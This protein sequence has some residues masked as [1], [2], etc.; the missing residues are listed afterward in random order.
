MVSQ[1]TGSHHQSQVAPRE[2]FDNGLEARLARL[3]SAV[4]AL[5]EAV[6]RLL[7]PSDPSPRRAGG[8]TWSEPPT[9]SQ[10]ATDDIPDLELE[11]LVYLRQLSDEDVSQRLK[12]LEERYRISSEAF[13]QWWLRGGADEIPE[14][15]QW[16]ALY[17]DWLRI[18]AETSKT[19]LSLCPHGTGRDPSVLAC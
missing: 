11:E 18:N 8:F 2:G 12:E 16:S 3:E 13:Y 4:A 6:A 19:Q 17:E 5:Q 14:K 9:Q 7:A 15:I 1:S 10:D